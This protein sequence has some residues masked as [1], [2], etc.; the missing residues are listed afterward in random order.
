MPHVLLEEEKKSSFLA[1]CAQITVGLLAAI[2]I[3]GML[4]ERSS[5]HGSIRLEADHYGNFRT[6][7]TINGHIT[8]GMADTGS[9]YLAISKQFARELG[10]KH[11]D[12]TL[13]MSTANGE[14]KG[15]P[16]TLSEV[17]VGPITLHN[18]AALVNGGK[19]S[20]CLL[21]QTFLG[22]LHV[23]MANGVMRISS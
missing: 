5:Q 15:A 3:M 8:V 12:Y 1:R 18:V 21:G 14:V 2:M 13:T 9:S 17:T 10:L 16:I 20:G 6:S 7:V 11:L 22:Q 23:V 19:F 4:A